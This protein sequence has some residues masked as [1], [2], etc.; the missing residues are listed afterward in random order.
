MTFE[1]FTES[2]VEE[3]A[4]AWLATAGC[5]VKNGAGMAPGE[6][7]AER[8]DPGQVILER[9]LRHGLQRRGAFPRGRASYRAPNAGRRL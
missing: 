4:L 8:F 5:A 6:L 7:L 9:R 3:G 2:V 1:Q